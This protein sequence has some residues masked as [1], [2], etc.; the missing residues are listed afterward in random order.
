MIRFRAMAFGLAI[1]GMISVPSSN[2][3]A[4][5]GEKLAKGAKQSTT[6]VTEISA[7][8]EEQLANMEEITTSATTLANMAE[9]LN[10]VIK[11]FKL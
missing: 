2:V 11:K 4:Y 7:A 1:I 3:F 8:S 6:S 5:T 10:D 9:K